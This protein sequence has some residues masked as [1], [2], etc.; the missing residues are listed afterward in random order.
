MFLLLFK[1]RL[2]YICPGP[3]FLLNLTP[4]YLYVSNSTGSFTSASLPS[5]PHC[6]KTKRSLRPS[7]SSIYHLISMLFP[8]K[9]FQRSP[10]GLSNRSLPGHSLA[11][12]CLRPAPG[13]P[14][15]AP[16]P[17]SS[18]DRILP[19]C[20]GRPGRSTFSPF[21]RTAFSFRRHLCNAPLNS[22]LYRLPYEA[23][24]GPMGLS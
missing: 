16:S 18:P 15:S 13:G 8:I 14:R 24:S 6:E 3:H 12:G 17:R 19:G 22:Q 9:A 1:V 7:C 10:P 11:T 4:L 5:F 20:C 21:S 23:P 2:L